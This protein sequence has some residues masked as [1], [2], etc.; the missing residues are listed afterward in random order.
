MIPNKL[1]SFILKGNNNEAEIF[2]EWQN[3]DKDPNGNQDE[4]FLMEYEFLALIDSFCIL[5][6]Q[7][8]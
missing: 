7:S 2:K 1:F 8:Y 5:N 4:A 3:F 6:Y